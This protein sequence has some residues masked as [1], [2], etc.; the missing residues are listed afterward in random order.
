MTLIEKMMM[1]D[2]VRFEVRPLD[3]AEGGGYLIEFPELSGCIADEK[4][5][6]EAMQ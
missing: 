1:N 5:P 2:F 6:E 3:K 4:T